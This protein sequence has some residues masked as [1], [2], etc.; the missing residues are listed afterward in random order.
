[1]ATP[2]TSEDIMITMTTCVLQD[3]EGGIRKIADHLGKS[4]SDDVIKSIAE[5]VTFAGMQKTYKNLEDKLGEEGKKM[6][7]L[8]GMVP[9]LLKGE[10]C[11]EQR[12]GLKR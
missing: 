12:K 9:Y 4:L 3:L 11:Y 6:T 7:H 8:F 10:I 2:S 1:M 5:R